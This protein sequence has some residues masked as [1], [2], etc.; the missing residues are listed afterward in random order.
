MQTARRGLGC[1]PPHTGQKRTNRHGKNAHDGCLCSTVLH[2]M[3]GRLPH[4]LRA[5]RARPAEGNKYFRGRGRGEAPSLQ[6][7]TCLRT[8]HALP[9][10]SG[11]KCQWCALWLSIG[12][13]NSRAT[14]VSQNHMIMQKETRPQHLERP[15]CLRMEQ[16]GRKRGVFF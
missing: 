12:A 14:A 2:G 5:R 13:S 6:T 4:Q 9:R 15:L 7:R 3:P 1:H 8:S 16:T 10:S 11:S